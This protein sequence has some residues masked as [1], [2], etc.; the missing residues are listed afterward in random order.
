MFEQRLEIEAVRHLSPRQFVLELDSAEIAAEAEPG[1]FVMMS[2]RE[3]VDPLL[4][5][6]MAVYRVLRDEAGR[7]RGFSLLIEVHGR[8][9]ALLARSRPGDPIRVLGPLGRP[10]AAPPAAEGHEHLLVMG[11]V[12]SVPFPFLCERLL[13]A[14]RPVRAFV[15]ARTADDLLCVEDFEEMAVPVEIATDDGSRGVHGFVTVPLERYLDDNPDGTAA[16][17]AC[18]PT[19][20]LR[21]VDRLARQRDLPL[22]VSLEA[23]MACG[24]GV[25]L[26]CV[27]RVR[28]GDRWRYARICREG[29]VFDSRDL[30][31][32]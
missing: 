6:P 27:V 17:Y 3:A 30:L 29:P 19:P 32:R 7:P 16:I 11:G 25:C 14:D 12:G 23:P 22:Q 26:S 31:W 24:Y 9:T 15:G 10:F 21:A 18:G 4:R 13:R 28:S 5:R 2:V 8:G 20:M 1:Q